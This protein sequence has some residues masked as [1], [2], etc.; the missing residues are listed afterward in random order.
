MRKFMT[1][2]M[3]MIISVISP[4]AS[5]ATQVD[6]MG[7]TTFKNVDIPGFH[8]GNATGNNGEALPTDDPNA[9]HEGN[10]VGI[11]YKWCIDD[12]VDIEKG[13]TTTVT[14]PPNSVL[15]TDTEFDILDGNQNVVGHFS[16]KKGEATG[17]ITWNGYFK[18]HPNN[19]CGEISFAVHGD[20][21]DPNRASFIAKNGW[22]IG[23][24]DEQGHY[25][26]IMWNL[27]I[28]PASRTLTDTVVTDGFTNPEYHSIDEGSFRLTYKDGGTDQ[29]EVP[30][31]VYNL[32]VDQSTG[33]FVMTFNGELKRPVQV[34]Y[35]STLKEGIEYLQNG[36]TTLF[37]NDVN[38]KANENGNPVTEDAYKEVVLSGG[39]SGVGED[40]GKIEVI[41]HDE[42]D[43]NLLLAGAEFDVYDS[44]GNVVDHI[45]VGEDGHGLTAKRMLVGEYKLIETK[46]PEG[47][48]IDETPHYV[49]VEGTETA[50]IVIYIGNKR[51][52]PVKGSIEVIK[53]DSLDKKK[54]LAGAEFDVFDATGEV[55]DH[56]IVG[57]NGH[58]LTTVPLDF[59]E[60]TLVETK[61]PEG[62]ELDST[63]IPVS[64][65]EGKESNVITVDVDNRQLP[66]E[67]VIPV[68]PGKGTIEVIKHDSLDK[69][70]LLAGAEFDVKDAEGNVIDHI[71]TGEDGHGMTTVP[72]DFGEYTLVET[73]APD[74]YKLDSKPIQVTVVEGEENNVATVDVLNTKLPEKPTK[75]EYPV[76][77]EKP[78]TPGKPGQPTE[79]G[80][81]KVP[82]TPN[83]NI[84]PQ[85]SEV[86][87]SY[88][89]L[90]GS[91]LL[92]GLAFIQVRRFK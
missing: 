34:L 71:V 78:T 82:N 69:E 10:P 47:Y 22:V 76:D 74:G 8:G 9:W 39:G 49:K 36:K 31:D 89:T 83:H 54:L 86:N 85:T 16:G 58:G 59:G 43:E 25:H 64:V 70:K 28:N 51:P 75:P 67:P 21:P 65:V 73:K 3:V 20:R 53:H 19:K 42:D 46:A 44:T 60:Y 15:D 27:L 68:L 66:G 14:L 72:L 4:L 45:V 84:L 41:K 90:I 7:G 26:Q 11:N 52:E 37:R 2:L 48:E 79:P 63:P 35:T 18:E 62:Y 80:K 29:E 61:A 88:L 33:S 91:V 57:E 56:I 87:S 55:V 77:P 12:N 5:L 6:D 13:D 38:L 32:S 24:P 23:E 81:P 30:A 92:I 1:V 40:A 50:T 17:T